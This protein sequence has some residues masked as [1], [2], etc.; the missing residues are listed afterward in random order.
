MVGKD[1]SVELLMVTNKEHI[2]PVLLFQNVSQFALVV[3][4]RARVLV[5]L[6]RGAVGF[7][8]F[9]TNIIFGREL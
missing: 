3:P 6:D 4:L 2:G 7:E 8:L 9:M 5:P 1:E